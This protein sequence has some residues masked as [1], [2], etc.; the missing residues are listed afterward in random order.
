ME[1]CHDQEDRFDLTNFVIHNPNHSVLWP[2]QYFDNGV[3]DEEYIH[4]AGE[5]K[6]AQ[7]FLNQFPEAE[8]LVDRNSKL[9]IDFQFDKV[10]PATTE[11]AWEGIR[12]RVFVN[13][14]SKCTEDTIIQCDDQSARSNFVEV[15]LIEYI[16]QY[17]QSQSCP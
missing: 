3:S 15:E 11:Q 4:I 5:T 13:P 7:A 6:E 14:E 17:S 1:I 8:I 9:A 2:R 12:L 16:E 10:L